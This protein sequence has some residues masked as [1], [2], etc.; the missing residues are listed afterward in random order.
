MANTGSKRIAE[1]Y[2]KALFDIASK[3]NVLAQVEADLKS[4]G[5][6]LAES[7]EL[8]DFLANPLLDRKQHAAALTAILG[9]IKAQKLTVDFIA[10]LATQKRLGVLA[11]IISLFAEWAEKSRGEA[12]AEV[13]SAAPL[14]DADTKALKDALAKVYGKKINLQLKQ[15]AS[16]LGGMVVKI[17][18]IQLDSSLAGKLDRLQQSLKAA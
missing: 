11:E 7:A 14:S 9:K 4:L 12:T 18:S 2:V 6:A 17:G 15:D 10:N 1:R 5:S 16:L 13:T 3:D 8:R